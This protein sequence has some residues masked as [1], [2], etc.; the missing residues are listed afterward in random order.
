MSA[1]IPVAHSTA[2]ATYPAEQ[3]APPSSDFST[4]EFFEF[5]L[6][7]RLPEQEYFWKSR[8]QKAERQADKDIDAGRTLRFSNAEAAITYLHSPEV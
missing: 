3:P 6:T 2:L 7:E 8:W 4:I 5:E 1:R